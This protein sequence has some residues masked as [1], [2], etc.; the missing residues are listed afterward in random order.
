MILV[1]C[2]SLKPAAVLAVFDHMWKFFALLIERVN[3]MNAESV[4]NGLWIEAKLF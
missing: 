2:P 3:M 1:G 4:L